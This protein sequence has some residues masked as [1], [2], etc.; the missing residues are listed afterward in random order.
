VDQDPSNFATLNTP[1]G[2]IANESL[3]VTNKAIAAPYYQPGYLVGFVASNP[4]ELLTLDLL[5]S[6]TVN[7]LLNGVPAD[8]AGATVSSPLRLDLLTLLA[9]PQSAFIGFT[10][11]KPFNAI[12]IADGSLLSAIGQVNVYQAC[13]STKPVT[14]SSSSSS[15][16]SGGSSS[17]SSSSSGGS[18]SSGSSSSSGATGAPAAAVSISIPQTTPVTPGSQFTLIYTGPSTTTSTCTASNTAGDPAWSGTI[19]GLNGSVVL[20]APAT[21]NV[22]NYTISC[23]V[24]TGGTSSAGAQLYDGIPGPV[25]ADCG[26]TDNL[27]LSVP[28]KNLTATNSSVSIGSGGL[29]LLCSVTQ[30]QNVVNQSPTSPTNYG[31]GHDYAVLN[32]PVGLI[33]NESLTVSSYTAFA[34]GNV[35]GFITSTPGELLTLS[36][37]NS[38]SVN[39]LLGGVVQETAG[40][41]TSAPLQLDLLALLASPNASFLGFVTSKPFDSVQ[42]VDGSLVSAIGQLDVYQ[43]CVGSQ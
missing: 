8:S 36:L 42:V 5:Q 33:A 20:T 27:G 3:T 21:P 31:T 35:A 12:Q 13:V 34:G 38:V 40:A 15:S 39:T 14:V 1:V 9:S 26:V 2:L 18:S 22:Y 28:T 25:A 19:T 23:G 6:V 24:S 37:L 11:T 10:A 41:S 32:T 30:P 29:C 43:A 17:S 16:S 7:T 4:A